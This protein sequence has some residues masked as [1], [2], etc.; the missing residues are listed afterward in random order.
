MDYAHNPHG[1]RAL[2]DMAAVRHALELARLGD[3]LLLT[4]HAKRKEVISLLT[5]MQAEGWQPGKGLPEFQQ[6]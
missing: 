5:Q 6:D 1:F 4:T 3:L 2:F